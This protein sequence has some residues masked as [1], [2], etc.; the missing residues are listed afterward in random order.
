[1]RYAVIIV[2]VFIVSMLILVNSCSSEPPDGNLPVPTVPVKN[3]KADKI[4]PEQIIKQVK[5][6]E[7]FSLS[8]ESNP[9]TGFD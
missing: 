6:G 9:S 3:Q 2:V 4:E 1:V 7:V 8:L 5:V